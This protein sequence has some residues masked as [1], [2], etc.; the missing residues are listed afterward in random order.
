MLIAHGPLGY[1]IAYASQRYWQP[2]V[3]KPQHKLVF[4]AAAIGGIFPDID[5]FYF[6]FINSSVSHRQ[7]LTHSF[8]TYGLVLLIALLWLRFIPYLKIAAICLL[9]FTLGAISHIC[10]DMFIGMAAGLAPMSNVIFGL[11]SI[12]WYRD[13]V[14][15]QYNLAT[16]FT[17]ELVIIMVAIGTLI[18]RWKLWLVVSAGAG[19]AVALTFI[20]LNGH[21]YKPDGWFYYSDADQDGAIN[22]AD[23]DIDGDQLVNMIDPDIDNDGIDNSQAF[24]LELFSAEQALFDYSFGYP[25]EIALRLSLVNDQVMVQRLF[26]NSGIFFTTEMANDYAARPDGYLFEPT[27]NQ[28]A[29]EPSNVINWLDHT[30]HLLPADAQ[31][32]EFDLVFFQSGVVAVFTRLDDGTDVVLDVDA[33]HP[34][35]RYEAYTTVAEREG[36]VIAIGRVLPKPYSKRY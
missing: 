30:N 13:S 8:L 36:G 4:W 20:W 22:A 27:N 9:F 19:V 34:Y 10:A 6:Y 33:S 31:R 32:Q 16:N 28:F 5:L 11:I 24:Y 17:A 21:A 3:A 15:I 2:L 12:P 35:T 25:L 7:L 23:R 29:E 18:K 14:F 1:L 26:A